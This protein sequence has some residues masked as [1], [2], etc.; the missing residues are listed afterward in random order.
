MQPELNLPLGNTVQVIVFCS[1]LYTLL[2]VSRPTY[3]YFLLL[4]TKPTLS[5]EAL[6]RLR[7][8]I[9]SCFSYR[10]KR[11][12]LTKALTESYSS[13]GLVRVI[14]DWSYKLRNEALLVVV[15]VVVMVEAELHRHGC[16]I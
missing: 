12:D 13:A 6:A 4:T 1:L 15:V 16:C 14:D 5:F 2:H 11:R 9:R 10:K 8:F 3:M 7:V